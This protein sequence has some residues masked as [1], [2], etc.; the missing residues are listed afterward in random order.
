MRYVGQSHELTV[1]VQRGD[2]HEADLEALV[3]RF[4]EEH[5]RV[6]GHAPD[7]PVQIVTYRLTASAPVTRSTDGT[8]SELP[9]EDGPA[10]TGVRRVHFRESGS[11]V[12][13]PI[14]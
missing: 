11:F 2:F 10:K 8:R 9:A 13:C 3:S 1:T 14:Y 6:Y 5:V 4:R 7:A 12:E